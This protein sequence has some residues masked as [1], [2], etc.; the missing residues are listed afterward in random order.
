MTSGGKSFN[1]FFEN[2]LTKF[3]AQFNLQLQLIRRRKKY[4]PQLFPGSILLPPVNGVDAAW[5]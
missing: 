5:P 1:D 4:F 2:R 3:R